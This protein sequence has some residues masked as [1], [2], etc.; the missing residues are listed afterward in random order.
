MI[1]ENSRRSRASAVT[2]SG[3]RILRLSLPWVGSAFLLYWVSRGVEM[4]QVR[5]V[6]R[7][8]PL[9]IFFALWLPPEAL[10][11]VLNVLSYKLLLDWF[12]K[13]ASF[14]KLWGPIA[15][16][17]LLG[18]INPLLGVGG[19]LAWLNRKQGTPAV[20]LGGVMLF[21]L[22]VD[23][24]FYLVM[25]TIGLFYL[26]DLPAASVPAGAVRFLAVSALFGIT[27]YAYFYLF[28]I[29]KFDFG[30]LGFQRRVKAFAPFNLARPRHYLCY[31]LVRTFFYFAFF[32]RQYLVMVF[33]FAITFPLGRYLSLVPLANALAALPVSVAGYGATQVV[34]LEF[35]R[36]YISA[37]RVVAFTLALNF[38]YTLNALLI[39][40]IGLVKLA[41]DFR[42]RN[43]GA[44]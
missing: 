23:M 16:S 27:F 33:C 21:L 10:I 41:W 13:P 14:R 18:L 25:I 3:T 17:Y 29:R 20:D 38:A 37:P 32:L 2:L 31:L 40:F 11:F 44:A 15:A 26:D 22:A 12:L 30:V 8:I 1:S 5:E 24:F 19:V 42:G 34:W 28:W 9:P 4:T 35:F 36:E 43:P 7:Q 6:F 39:G